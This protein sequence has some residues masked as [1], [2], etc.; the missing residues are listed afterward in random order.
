MVL[1]LGPV[2]G[3]GGPGLIGPGVALGG[4]RPFRP[5]FGSA[6]GPGVAVGRVPLGGGGSVG[7]LTPR[8]PGEPRGCPQGCRQAFSLRGC[9]RCLCGGDAFLCPG[10]SRCPFRCLF[11]SPEDRCCRCDCEEARRINTPVAPEAG[12]DRQ[13][14]ILVRVPGRG[15]AVLTPD[16]L[17][18]APGP[19]PDRVPGVDAEEPPAVA[20][21]EP[22]AAAPAPEVPA[23]GADEGPANR[24]PV[25]LDPDAELI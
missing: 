4:R 15:V 3:L 12:G 9:R 13:R 17:Q 24:P 2:G 19:A 5:G 10:V 7:V 25:G 21:A 8:C 23:E 18:R 16:V 6:F 14:V 11:T 22:P 1:G 20:P